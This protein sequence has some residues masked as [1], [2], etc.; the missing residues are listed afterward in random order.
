MTPKTRLACLNATRDLWALRHWL[1][2]FGMK[3]A[4]MIKSTTEAVGS[5]E[6]VMMNERFQVLGDHS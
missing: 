5:T 4:N 3:L 6:G 1:D 2:I